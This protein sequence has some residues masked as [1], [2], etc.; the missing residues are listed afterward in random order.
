[1]SHDYLVIGNLWGDGDELLLK[2]HRIAYAV[3]MATPA[4]DSIRIT[5]NTDVCTGPG[6]RRA[7][8][9]RPSQDADCDGSTLASRG[10]DPPRH[11]LLVGGRR[12]SGTHRG[13]VVNTKTYRRVLDNAH[14]VRRMSRNVLLYDHLDEAI[15]H[16]EAGRQSESEQMLR[17]VRILARLGAQN[18]AGAVA[19]HPAAAGRPSH[20]SAPAPANTTSMG[21][22]SAPDP[23]PAAVCQRGSGSR[24]GTPAP[25]PI[26][27]TLAGEE[28]TSEQQSAGSRSVPASCSVSHAD[29]SSPA[30]QT[31]GVRR[32]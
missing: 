11:L 3:A 29:A 14:A 5:P 16:A 21:A 17:T 1:M 28:V 6:R 32:G 18:L 2:E 24:R 8:L 26:E 23:D 25:A 7:A 27:N 12:A 10:H 4:P 20:P 9:R 31:V 13:P 19:A 22:G 30:E 15:A